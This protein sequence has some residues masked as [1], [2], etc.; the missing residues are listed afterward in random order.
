MR[1]AIESFRG[2][3]PRVTPRA[4]PDNAAQDATNASLLTGDLR[5]WRQFAT[6][7]GLA[8]VGL[9]NTIYLLNDKWLSWTAQ[10]DVARGTIAGDTTYRTYLTAPS[11]YGAP[12]WTNY[13]LATTGPPP[14][15]VTTHPLGVPAPDSVPTLVVTVNPSDP[16]SISVTD[17]GS[18]LATS[19]TTSGQI[20]GA[21]EVTQDASFGNPAPS[22]RLFEDNQ[23]CFAY[24]DFGTSDS[25][26]TKFVAQFNF[27]AGDGNHQAGFVIGNTATGAGVRAQIGTNG[28]NAIF[29]LGTGTAWDV[30]WVASTT[31][32]ITLSG[33][34]WYTFECDTTYNPDGTTSVNAYVRDAANTTTI[35][36]LA[37]RQPF[38]KG[39]FFGFTTHGTSTDQATHYDNIAVSGSGSLNPA[40]IVNVATSYV[41]TFV[42]DIG[43]E[44]APSL[45][46]ATIVR[47]DGVSVAV[48]TSTSIPTG[49]SSDYN[50]TK[51]RI[52]RAATGTTGTAFRFVAEIPLA[53]A[54]YNDVLTDAQLG[55]V[56]PSDNWALPP[57]DLERILALPNGVM[58]GF[59]KNQLCLSAQNQP[60][61]WPVE[62]RLNTDTKIIGIGNI[63]TTVVIGTES[64]VY[65]A[66]GND[67]AAYSM[68]KS[69][70]PYAC[71]SKRSFAYLT[72]IGVVFAGP[73]G[74]MAVA[75][76]GQIQ[77]LTE[78]VFTREQWQALNP[79]SIIGVAHNNIYWMF[80][81]SGSNS[82]CYAIDMKQDGF[83]IVP[84][85]FH[86]SAAYVDPIADKFYLVLDM[87]NEP[88]DDLLPVRAN[89]PHYI[90]GE[91]IFQFDGNPSVLMTYRYRGKLWLLEHPTWM[92][93]LQVKAADYHNIVLRLYGDGTLIDEIV[94]TEETEFTLSD[95]SE[96]YTS[97]EFE[98]IGTSPVRV[99][100]AAED[101]TELD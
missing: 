58:A 37:L 67:P 55:E 52:Y 26:S 47:P 9:V 23:T 12:R 3:A 79:S 35:G 60:H 69:E 91:T 78:S 54:T 32:T 99:I 19:W 86:A 24:R 51:K 6:T 38:T 83:G 77:N 46:S 88:D 49:I 95:V 11:F 40:T 68:A 65:V 75:G 64:F 81:Q 89:P 61:A 66:S 80:W 25:S 98:V 16:T 70:V 74:L 57:D 31:E 85:A 53:T 82:G 2:E 87:D 21:R 48:T 39:G 62:F 42:N 5:S 30:E 15:P 41:Y 33:V 59:S 56:L 14:Y 63:D 93:I 90:D 7:I 27:E 34:T 17:D 43:E 97:L 50:I 84:M 94:V 73:N 101:I 8:N 36:T 22:Y 71:V 20:P 4:L 1:R 100:Q 28:T 72:R 44:S 10:V 76:I 29:Q 96:A 13:A 45:P 92:S 18:N